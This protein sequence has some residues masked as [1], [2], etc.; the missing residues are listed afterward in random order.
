VKK[1]DF[2]KTL[3]NDPLYQSALKSAKTDEERKR[4][5]AITEDFV[6][7]FADVLGPLINRAENDPVFREQMKRSLVEDEGVITDVE[8]VASGSQG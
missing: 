2:L 8:S 6:G 5:I 1:E 7:Q 3:R 4:V